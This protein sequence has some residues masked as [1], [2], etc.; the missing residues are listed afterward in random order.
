MPI[1]ETCPL[2]LVVLA[3]C[4]D[5]YT[6]LL[7]I[8][9][10]TCE[11]TRCTAPTCLLSCFSSLFA[12]AVLL[13][14]SVK[15][16]LGLCSFSGSVCDLV[17]LIE[18]FRLIVRIAVSQK[19]ISI[20][21]LANTTWRIPWLPAAFLTYPS[22]E[23]PSNRALLSLVLGR[24][25]SWDMLARG[26]MKAH[27]HCDL[28]PPC[29]TSISERSGSGCTLHCYMLGLNCYTVGQPNVLWD[30]TKLINQFFKPVRF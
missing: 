6:H 30:G 23:A 19:R 5:L 15:C 9:N 1:R 18:G 2:H 20:T 11:E 8:L 26:C 29:S 4:L 22:K 7:P 21:I 10:H 24:L 3:P 16:G 14:S 28:L 12:H 27:K 13:F 25:I 17:L